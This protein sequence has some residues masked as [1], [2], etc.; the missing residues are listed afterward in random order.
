MADALPTDWTQGRLGDLADW[1]SGGTPRTSTP[2]YWNGDIPWIT[3]GSLT[4]F[5]LSDSIRRITELGLHNGSRLVPE[6]TIIFVVRGMSLK[7]EFRVGI[8]KRPVA[9]GQDCK[10]LVPKSTV[11]PLFLAQAIRARSDVVLSM[12]DEAGHG[13]G[14]L[15]TDRI[16]SLPI[17]LPPLPEQRAI[18][19][20]LSALDDKLEMNL[21]MS[22]VLTALRTSLFEEWYAKC[23]GQTVNLGS[24]VNVY[25]GVSYSGKD[26][27]GEG[28]PMITLGSFRRDGS[29]NPEGVRHYSGD[30]KPRHRLKPGDIVVANTDI[31]QD[32]DV[33]GRPAIVPPLG[34]VVL[35]S[36]HV[37]H[38]VPKRATN[39]I[40][41]FLFGLLNTS[42]FRNRVAGFATGTTV[43]AMPKEAITE[44]SLHL[45]SDTDIET[46]GH[47]VQPFYELER[48]NVQQSLI[49]EE[50]RDA[51]LPKL[52]SGELRVRD[53]EALVGQ[54]V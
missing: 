27:D 17:A 32:R 24:L 19:A 44:C 47:R 8:T 38:V 9:F 45:P 23:D 41:L 31:T 49:I 20:V 10:A 34:E 39:G 48:A 36:H 28:L 5:Y 15:A 43:L 50:I 14:R 25:R 29:F 46:F 54:A 12:V 11:D 13:T 3:S 16:K 33:L 18:A 42:R 37:S 7:T 2:S 35:C 21:K 52:L 53:A 26:M 22:A 30:F 6:H 40:E 4:T 51:L 1:F